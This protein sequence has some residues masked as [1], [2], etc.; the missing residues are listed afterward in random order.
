MPATE[1]VKYQIDGGYFVAGDAD[2]A[3]HFVAQLAIKLGR[4][5]CTCSLCCKVLKIDELAKPSGQWCEHC[6]P[7]CGCTIYNNRPPV[8]RAFA[9]QWM[10]DNSF[11]EE[12]KPSRSRMVLRMRP[13]PTGGLILNVNVDPAYPHI[14]RK[15]PY[16]EELK[17]RASRM[18]VN[19]FVGKRRFA[20][21][22]E[23]EVETGQDDAVFFHPGGH[24]VLSQDKANK[25]L[26]AVAAMR[27]GAP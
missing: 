13:S 9:C 7:G 24:T 1:P 14:W 12:W 2:G 25:I 21:L 15:S 10:T 18:P 17:D 4:S 6:K 3:E 22:G 16:Y 5:C 11:G 19:V 8:C 20:L 23:R 26:A 27:S